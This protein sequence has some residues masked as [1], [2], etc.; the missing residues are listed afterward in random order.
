[1]SKREVG[2]ALKQKV[3]GIL[4]HGALC[5]EDFIS[6]LT[7]AENMPGGANQ[8]IDS[9]CRALF[10]LI[11][12]RR[13]VGMEA[14]PQEHFIQLDNTWKTTRTGFSSHFAIFW[15]TKVSSIG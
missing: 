12:K 5:R 10:V 6:L 14:F 3:T 2:M 15:F 7:A 13:A 11:E 4:F 1:M 9:F 8:T